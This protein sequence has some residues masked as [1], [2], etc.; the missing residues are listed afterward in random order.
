MSAR[1]FDSLNFSQR[2]GDS[3]DSVRSNLRLAAGALDVPASRLYFLSQVH[4]TEV[5][6]LAGSE[7]RAEVVKRTGDVTLSKSPDVACGVRIAD[8]VPVLI[9]DR[10]SGA[11]AA[12]HSGWQ[13]TALGVVGAA[14]MAMRKLISGEGELVAA[15][16]PH[17]ERCC[18][19]VGEDV[20]ERLSAC[21]PFENG[22][23]DRGAGPKPHVD[24]RA[25]VRSQL[26]ALGLEDE[27]IDDVHG[28]TRCDSSKFFSYR[29]DKEKSG[30]HLAAIVTRV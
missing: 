16:G 4:G 30:R 25:I 6:E 19:E 11:T 13:G 5:V 2:V 27:A 21:A 29:R 9:G 17:I 8:C 7:D 28:C 18:F 20:A 24:L 26:R 12:I 23:V 1:P 14:V 15:I 3:A 10:Q 22:V